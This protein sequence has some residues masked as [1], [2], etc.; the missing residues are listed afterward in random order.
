MNW[1]SHF[2]PRASLIQ[3]SIVREFLKFAGRPDMI[4]FAG[5]L[6]DP[7][8]LPVDQTRGAVDR[9][10]TRYGPQMLQ[11]GITDG[12]LELRALLAAKFQKIG[13]TPENVLITT[14]SQ[15][16]LDLIGRV[17]LDDRSKIAVQNPTYLAAL[18]AFR[19][20]GVSFLPGSVNSPLPEETETVPDLIYCIP[21]FTNPTGESVPSEQRVDLVRYSFRHGI[22]LI[23]DDPYGALTFD[24]SVAAPSLL[25]IGMDVN[26]P[27]MHVGTLSKVLAPGFRI[28][29]IVAARELV[30]KLVVAKQSLDLHTSTFSQY[31]V[32][33]LITEGVL[34]KLL[35]ELRAAYAHKC[36]LMVRSIHATMP[37]KVDCTRPRGGFFLLLKLP[38]PLDGKQVAQAALA[39]NVAV[40]PGVEFHVQGGENTLRL[41]FSHPASHQIEEGIRRLARV[42]SA[43]E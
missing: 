12:I 28:G 36:Q 13:A 38:S 35:P 25:E 23:E 7:R 31:A 6:P 17:L 34:D 1:E 41:C 19:A 14:G 2:T 8:L 33:Q 37:A 9:A 10:L 4:S 5:G 26:G 11:Y 16:A 21:N 3:K 24:E 42:I 29:W 27:V 43:H 40:V 15:Q 18:S 39:A 32:L 30:R 20:C 22:P